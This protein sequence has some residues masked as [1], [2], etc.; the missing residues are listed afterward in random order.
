M[1]ALFTK[2]DKKLK[3]M[4]PEEYDK[5]RFINSHRASWQFFAKEVK[6][7]PFEAQKILGS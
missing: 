1:A 5:A 4:N 6:K 2:P 7:S 3:E